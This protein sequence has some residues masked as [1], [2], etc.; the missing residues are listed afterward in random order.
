MLGLWK[1]GPL[2]SLKMYDS[3]GETSARSHEIGTIG[4][5]DAAIRETDHSKIIKDLI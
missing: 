4:A 5:G 1:A 2:V 3:L